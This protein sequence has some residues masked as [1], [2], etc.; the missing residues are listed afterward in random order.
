VQAGIG[1]ARIDLLQH[2]LAAPQYRGALVVVAWEHREIVALARAL[3]GANGGDPSQVP[4]WPGRDF[5]SLYVVRITRG[6]GAAQ[7]S[8]TRM[9]QGL[10]GQAT[11]CP[12]S[13]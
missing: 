12:G 7:A 10:D 11:A 6:A 8:F 3:L 5:D 4:R 2:A 13:P 9:R 1:V